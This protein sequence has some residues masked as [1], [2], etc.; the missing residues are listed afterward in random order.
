[1]VKKNKMLNILSKKVV[2][3]LPNSD[4]MASKTKWNDDYWLMLMQVYLSSPVG[5]KPL[6]SRRMVELSLELHISP[7]QLR[8]RMQQ[9]ASLDTPRIERLMATYANKPNKLSRAVRLLREM[10]GF[11]NADE[12]Y[13]G[14]EVNETFELDF[15]PL[16][17][18][19]RLTPAALII[20]LD[21][22]FKLTPATMVAVTP[23]VIQ[24]A[25][26]LRIPP[27]EVAELLNIYIYCDPC[28]KRREMIFSPLMIPCMQIWQRY[29]ND[30]EQLDQMAKELTEYYK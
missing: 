8:Q 7:Q 23:E 24:T 14:V 21:L 3:L 6:Y 5:V 18:D 10:K 17:Q 1:M 9:L 29:S 2:T 28:L 15:R 26:L 12:F 16:D 20:I 27:D 22:Y 13:S 25:K 4:I 30:V 19:S 11:G